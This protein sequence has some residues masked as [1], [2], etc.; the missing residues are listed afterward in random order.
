[1]KNSI[2]F[3]PCKVHSWSAYTCTSA[4]QFENPA[5]CKRLLEGW[6]RDASDQ[7]THRQI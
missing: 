1:M 2:F 5:S 3:H 4:A 6:Q 7:S